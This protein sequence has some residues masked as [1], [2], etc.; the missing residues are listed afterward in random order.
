M[1]IAL[2]Q[3]GVNLDFQVKF[4]LEGQRP[5]V[6]KTAGTLTKVFLHPWSKFGDPSL[7]GSR[8]MA[9]IS[10]WLIQTDTHTRSQRHHPKTKTGLW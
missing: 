1:S 2:A 4:E 6:H 9:R 10:K 5:S 7:K 8:I 3:H